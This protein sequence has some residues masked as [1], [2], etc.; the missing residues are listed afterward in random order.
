MKSAKQITCLTILAMLITSIAAPTHPAVGGSDDESQRRGGSRFRRALG[1]RVAR[2]ALQAVRE[3]DPV[4]ED[5]LKMAMHELGAELRGGMKDA[6]RE[7]LQ[8]ENVRDMLRGIGAA[9]GHVGQGIRDGQQDIGQRIA[10]NI[11][12][13]YAPM[14]TLLGSLVGVGAGIALYK[15]RVSRNKSIAGG[16]A[17]GLGFL[18]LS[19]LS[20]AA[21]G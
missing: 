20:R 16:S 9:G 7:A 4:I 13:F 15:L 10:D 12:G 11:G 5:A 3:P 21:M 1:R 17:V 18:T 2:E 19:L 14:A 8:D 6:V